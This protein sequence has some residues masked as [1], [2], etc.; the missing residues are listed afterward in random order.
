MRIAALIMAAGE[1][2][3]FGDC[4]HLQ[5]INEKTL[6]QRLTDGLLA[7]GISDINIISGAWHGQHKQ[8]KPSGT[9]LTY[10]PLWQ[11]GLGSSIAFGAKQV[12][13][14][15][16]GILVVL[17]DQAAL[18]KDDFATLIHHFDGTNSVC[19]AYSGDIGVPAI[20]ARSEWPLLKSLYGD[21]GAKQMLKNC[22][23]IEQINIPSA[24]ID[25]DTVEDLAALTAT[26]TQ[27]R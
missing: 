23:S 4:K 11:E 16:D 2:S 17:G 19:A 8:K 24:A 3:R 1:A 7:N 25:I 12:S 5:T 14:H 6:L 9:Q 22:A 18:N 20:F 15:V 27:T 10:N 21:K 26:Q 13:Q